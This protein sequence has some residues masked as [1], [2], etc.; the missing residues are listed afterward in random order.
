MKNSAVFRLVFAA[1]AAAPAA[2]LAHPGDHIAMSAGQVLHHVLTSP[3]HLAE[4]GLFGVLIA[5]VVIRWRR[6][7]RRGAS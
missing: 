2:A 5:A 4:L 7:V 3:D 6:R 1:A